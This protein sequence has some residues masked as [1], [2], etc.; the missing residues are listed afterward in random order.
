[1]LFLTAEYLEWYSGGINKIFSPLC[2]IQSLFRPT[3]PL[4]SWACSGLALLVVRSTE[5]LRQRLLP[6]IRIE[7][8]SG[9]NASG[10]MRPLP[11]RVVRHAPLCGSHILT[12]LSQDAEASLFELGEK[13]TKLTTCLCPIS[14]CRHAPVCASQTLTVLSHEA[15]AIFVDSGEK[16][17]ELTMQV[18]PIS[19]RTHA[20]VRVS[21][22]LIVL[23]RD[24][25][26]N[27]AKD[28]K[29]TEFTGRV[30]PV[31]V[32]RQNPLCMSQILTVLSSDI[33]TSLFISGEKATAWIVLLCSLSVWRHNPFCASQIVTVLSS[34]IDTSFVE[35]G[36]NTTGLTVLFGFG[37]VP[38]NLPQP[39]LP[40][41]WITMCLG[42]SCWNSCLIRLLVGLNSRGDTYVCRGYLSMISP[43]R[44][45]NW[46]AS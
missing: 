15:D 46:H 6:L 17:T 10:L 7:I 3:H 21:H 11:S 41:G 13:A 2:V 14:V 23:S 9:E 8:S 44:L 5:L 28:E 20:P 36:E 22:I 29:A 38:G 42:F 19:V 45:S 26:A 25:E 33:D 24:P 18:W 4:I 12:V 40:P 1:M 16:T 30:C 32:F 27:L 39:S 37:A 34:D 43:K 31:S 35:S